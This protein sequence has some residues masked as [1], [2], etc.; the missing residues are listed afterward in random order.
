[1]QATF[2]SPGPLPSP[3]F[4]CVGVRAGLY[5]LAETKIPHSL[6]QGTDPWFSS[7]LDSS[8]ATTPEWTQCGTCW[9]SVLG[10]RAV[11]L[12]YVWLDK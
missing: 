2:L 10:Q 9:L 3:V 4:N 6:I 7:C 1:M 12:P 11:L 8:L 5:A